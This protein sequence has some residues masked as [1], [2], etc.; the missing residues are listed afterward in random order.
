IDGCVTCPWH[1]WQYRPEDGASP[2][3]FKEVVHTYPVRVV[4][5]VVSVRPRPNPLATL[6]E[7]QAHG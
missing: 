5:G 2:P 1:G 7:E 6:P 4:G 3:P